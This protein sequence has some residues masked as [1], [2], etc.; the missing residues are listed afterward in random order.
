MAQ[1]QA[2]RSSQAI[3]LKGSTQLVTE[4]FEYSV[5][6][7]DDLYRTFLTRCSILYQRGVYPSD[8]FK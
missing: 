6:R 8:D 7:C 3:T 4:F 2:V 1:K 5:N